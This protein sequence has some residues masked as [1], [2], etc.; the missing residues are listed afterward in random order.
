MILIDCTD[1]LQLFQL[2]HCKSTNLFCE[3]DR[4]NHI[5]YKH[6]CKFPIINLRNIEFIQRNHQKLEV[7]QELVSRA[8][9]STRGSPFDVNVH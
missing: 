9:L 4:V 8:A 2:A 3:I 5:L 1:H 6:D 7:P